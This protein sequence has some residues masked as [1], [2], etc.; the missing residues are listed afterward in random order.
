MANKA[1]LRRIAFL[2]FCFVFLA[3]IGF[4]GNWFYKFSYHV[5]QLN[6]NLKNS[7]SELALVELNNVKYFDGVTRKWKMGW[8]V[9][10]YLLGR[11]RISLYDAQYDYLI[12]DYKKVAESRSL[13]NS[14]DYRA[15]HLIGSAKVRLLQAEYR[16][17]KN[18]E[19]KKKL[20][21]K[22][23]K[24]MEE[25][26]SPIFKKAVENSPE[27]SFPDPNFSDRFNYDITSDENASK[28]T[29]EMMQPGKK[30]LLGIPKDQKD[31]TPGPG[32]KKPDGEKK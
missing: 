25:E 22:L 17:E 11:G 1:L 30:I 14:V 29:L 7:D 9:D 19:T 3:A 5:D 28:R 18:S 32:D 20:L 27:F 13:Q 15:F 6:F 23:T 2:I 16:E 26:A 4:V 12:G 10:S 8:F 21:E 31:E 24:Q